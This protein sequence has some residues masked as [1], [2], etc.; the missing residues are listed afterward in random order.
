MK[1][2]LPTLLAVLMV[3]AVNLHADDSLSIKVKETKLRSAPKQFAPGIAS[4]RYGDRLSPISVKEDWVE[5]L[6][7]GKQKG[8][9]HSSALSSKKIVLSS[10]GDVKLDADATDVILAGKG[11]SKATEQEYARQNAGA[12]FGA[13]NTVESFRVSDAE[14]GNF[15]SEGQLGIS[16]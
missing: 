12:N 8:F 6:A 10:K 15:I 7:S 3:G 1:K 13:V 5:G 14:L 11:F 4:L 2:A 9:V 16:R